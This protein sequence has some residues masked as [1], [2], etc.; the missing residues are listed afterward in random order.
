MAAM[1][2]VVGPLSGRLVGRFGARWAL[3]L[4]GGAI[5][6][7]ALMLTGLRTDTSVAWLFSAYVVFGIGFGAVNP[8]I[9]NTAVSGMPAAQAGVA[10]AIASTSRQTGQSLGVALVGAIAVGTAT[11]GAAVAESSHPGWWIVAGC[12]GAIVVLAFVSTG[13]WARGTAE[14]AAAALEA[15]PS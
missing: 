5:G 2:V 10:A 13:A 8:P 3:V 15:R 6:V 4:G 11:S 12:A 14:R 1:T 7:S 9:T